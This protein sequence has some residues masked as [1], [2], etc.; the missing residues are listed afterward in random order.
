MDSPRSPR[1]LVVSI[2]AMGGD[3]APQA[4]I[5][6]VA[7]AHVRHPKVKFLLHGDHA[8]LQPALLGKPAVK[9]VAQ[10]VH[11]DDTVGMEDKPSQALRRGRNTSMWR[12]IDSVRSKEAQ[13]AVSAG[14]TGALMAM[15]MFQ[16]RT[17]PGLSRPAIAAIWPTIRGQ[18]VVL[19]VGANV[20]SDAR[21]LVDFAILGEA[22]ARIIFGIE[23]PSVG[24]L[25]IGAEEVKG[26]DAV[27]AA[28]A[29]LRAPGVS[30]RFHGFVEGDDISAGT[31]DVVVTSG[32]TGN[33]ALKTAEG[34][35][36][37]I[38][39][40]IRSA[41]SRSLFSRIGY[42]L[43]KPGF[44]I[45]RQKMDPRVANGGVFLGLNGTIVKSHGGTDGIGFAN[46]I[47]LAVE[48]AQSD[49]P[50]QIAD[51]MSHLPDSFA[52]LGGPKAPTIDTGDA[53]SAT[54]AVGTATQPAA[55]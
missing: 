2:D 50:S 42:L 36:R 1:E 25:N 15:S 29:A 19:D 9:N 22:F 52:A 54:E 26:N 27:K 28:A 17:I 38:G 49:F 11:C 41:M 20:D 34:T 44:G 5:D 12:A 8:R 13:V 55:E 6:G 51:A 37:L 45:L 40:Y 10:V 53:P 23:R 32:F 43:A 31:V 46:A 21:Q 14:N 4:I 35:A 48:M 24:L 33:I 47:D 39:H 16:L 7:I 30:M 18:T 3:N